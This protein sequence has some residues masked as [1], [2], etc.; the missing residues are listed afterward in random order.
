MENLD[1]NIDKKTVD[2]GWSAMR[3][4]LDREMP[5][6]ERR[7]RRWPFW[8]WLAA[9]PGLLIGAGLGAWGTFSEV[10]NKPVPTAQPAQS[11]P[12]AP[13]AEAIKP[14]LDKQN[15]ANTKETNEQSGNKNVGQVARNHAPATMPKSAQHI[16][17]QQK[18]TQATSPIFAPPTAASAANLTVAAVQNLPTKQPL[19]PS[20]QAIGNTAQ[21]PAAP[22]AILPRALAFLPEK[23][24]QQLV[25]EKLAI[26][27]WT[28]TVH[29]KPSNW[30]FGGTAAARSERMPNLTGFHA[31]AVA[32]WRFAKRFGLRTGVGYAFSQVASNSKPTGVEVDAI[33]YLDATGDSSFVKSLASTPSADYEAAESVFVPL[34]RQHRL[35]VPLLFWAQPFPKWRAYAGLT[36]SRL[37]RASAGDYSLTVSQLHQ[38]SGQLA[39]EYSSRV[40]DIVQQ[41]SPKWDARWQVGLGFWPSK[42]WEINVGIGRSFNTQTRAAVRAQDNANGF[43]PVKNEISTARLWPMVQL[44]G[45]YFF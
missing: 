19:P 11:A 42:K 21:T 45:A 27:N 12:V 31:G 44:G 13:V 35:E 25:F 6:P 1:K 8:F 3:D 14:T 10:K 26:E 39:D 36:V 5:V 20:A 29:E 18:T 30:A 4:L 7:R 41:H 38:F 33:T 2:R 34:A 32:D 15:E 17:N 24:G 9:L 28:K 43:N 40:N 23:T 16:G 37:I 22:L